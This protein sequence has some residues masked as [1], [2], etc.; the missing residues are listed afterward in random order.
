[1]R[2]M[3]GIKYLPLYGTGSKMLL[4]EACTSVTVCFLSSNYGTTAV[5]KIS[6]LKPERGPL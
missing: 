5:A 2:N 1:M 3:G 6:Q 4:K